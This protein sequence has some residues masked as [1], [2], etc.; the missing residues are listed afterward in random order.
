MAETEAS[1]TATPRI[2]DWTQTPWRKL[3]QHVYR[4]QKRIYRAQARGNTKAV[5]SLQRLLMKSRAA[6]TLAVRRVTQDNHGKKTAGVD[7]VKA[8]GPLVR[9]RFVETLRTPE[10]ITAR[11]VRRVYI[12]KPGKPHESRPLGIPVLLDRAHQALVK[13]ALEPQWEAR[14]EPDSYGFR[15]GRSCHDAIAAFFMQ[16]VFAPK[17]VLDADIKGC[18]DNISIT[19][20]LAKLDTTPALRRAI[21]AW[22]YAGMMDKGMVIPTTSGVPQ[23]GI[24]SP[25]LT[26]VALHGLQQAVEGAYVR[27]GHTPK[28]DPG[29][30]V[31]PRLLRY[32]DD[33]VVRC[34]DLDGITAARAVVERWLADM[35]LHLSPTK[36]RITHTLDPYEGAVGLDFLGFALRQYRVG[37]TR[38]GRLKGKVSTGFMVRITPSKDAVKRHIADL[39]AIVRR[40]RASTQ[41][42]LI[43]ALNAQIRAWRPYD[44]HVLCVE[45]FN[46]CDHAVYAMLRRWSRRRHPNKSARWIA[47]RYW[48]ESDGQRWCF[49]VPDGIR[50]IRHTAMH[51]E[52]YIK[53]R[54]MASP[55]D[56]NLIYWSRRLRTHWATGTPMAR[57]LRR[58]QGRCSSCGLTFRDEDRLEMHH[59]VR[60]ADGG[61]N[62]DSNLQALHVHCHDQ[63]TARQQAERNGYPRQGLPSRGAV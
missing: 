57:L 36:T 40:M 27:R 43:A 21:R 9:L 5:H 1:A 39:N 45:A 51:Q 7:G 14:F 42:A 18:F 28:G 56:G 12:P 52:Q 53:V 16:V 46:D 15:P 25:L 24:I 10:A 29:A 37:R 55:Y 60:P 6:R 2:E 48:H 38:A 3:E 62:L 31:R 63:L 8:V 33:F 47:N 59:I 22:L 26:N 32:A 49:R 35:G 61:T 58:Q 4:L 50:L 34:R 20:L 54:G 30:P 23:G 13:L 41:E 11:P 17:Y 19:A 44:R